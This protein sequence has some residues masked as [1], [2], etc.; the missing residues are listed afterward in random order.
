M[1]VECL[2][3]V[4]Y[5]T[6][7]VLNPLDF[8]QP[9]ILD[10]GAGEAENPGVVSVDAYVSADISAD[11]KNIPLPDDCVDYIYSSNALEHVGKREVVPALKEWNRIPKPG[12][13]L[14][15]LVPDLE[16]ACQFWLKYQNTEWPMDIIFGNQNHAGEYHKTGFNPKIL[17]EYFKECGG[18]DIKEIA[19][20]GGKEESTPIGNGRSKVEVEQRAIHLTAAK[21]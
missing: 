16:W 11:M 4:I 2:Q 7:A 17:E 18:W 12:G 8:P 9:L 15:L 10:I 1:A 13:E 5:R 20:S 14:Y 19:Y 3:Q 6:M 21:I